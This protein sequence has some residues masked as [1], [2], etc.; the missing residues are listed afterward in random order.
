MK[1]WSRNSKRTIIRC[2]LIRADNPAALVPRLPW[3]LTGFLVQA[4]NVAENN[5][6]CEWKPFSS[7][8]A[9]WILRNLLHLYFPKEE[10]WSRIGS[11]GNPS[12]S[13]LK[14]RD[15]WCLCQPIAGREWRI[16]SCS[17]RFGLRA[18]RPRRRQLLEQGCADNWCQHLRLRCVSGRSGSRYP[19]SGCIFF[20][21]VRAQHKPRGCTTI[22]VYFGPRVPMIN[23]ISLGMSWSDRQSHALIELLTNLVVNNSPASSGCKIVLS[24]EK[25]GT[26]LNCRKIYHRIECGLGSTFFI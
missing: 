24:I 17:L 6:L 1:K 9:A 23:V 26:E 18:V 11:I 19:R 22:F 13:P 14:C 25:G 8:W 5:F 3:R 4:P 20:R 15:G 10:H 7:V 16:G 12:R 21:K 2:H